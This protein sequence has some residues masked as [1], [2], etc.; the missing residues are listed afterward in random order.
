MSSDSTRPEPNRRRKRVLITSTVLLALVGLA[1]TDYGLA[2]DGHRPIFSIHGPIMEDGGT[3]TY[4]GLGYS[5]T[6]YAEMV[7]ADHPLVEHPTRDGIYHG[8][9]LR[10]GPELTCWFPPWRLSSVKY[11]AGDGIGP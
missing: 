8:Y 7:E 10:Q 6:I 1:L 11:Y 3:T 4:A 5:L 9:Y 2:L